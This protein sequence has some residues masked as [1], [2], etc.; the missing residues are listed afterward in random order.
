MT[1]THQTVP[2]F[3]SLIFKIDRFVVALVI[4]TQMLQ[5]AMN[6]LVDISTDKICIFGQCQVMDV[7]FGKE[8]KL[9]MSA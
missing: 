2:I 5:T 3:P 9:Q 4:K 7:F 8:A 1:E 6:S